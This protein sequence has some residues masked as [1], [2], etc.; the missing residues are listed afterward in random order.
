MTSPSENYSMTIYRPLLKLWREELVGY[1]KLSG[2][3]WREDSS[4]LNQ[5]Y[6]RNWIRQSL[7]EMLQ[8][9]DPA[10]AKNLERSLNVLAE[11]FAAK[12]G[13]KALSSKEMNEGRAVQLLNPVVLDRRPLLGLSESGQL[14]ALKHFLDKSIAARLTRDQVAEFR[15]RLESPRKQFRFRLA[16]ADWEVFGPFVALSRSHKSGHL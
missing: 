3:Q 1:A 5:D 10:L 12:G 2:L 7:I 14:G 9:R 16:G 8:K 13:K 6:F 11:E 15:K 4:N